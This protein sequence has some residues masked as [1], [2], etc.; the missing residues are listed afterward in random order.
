MALHSTSLLNPPPLPPMLNGVEFYVTECENVMPAETAPFGD[1]AKPFRACTVL[2]SFASGDAER[3]ALLPLRHALAF[4]QTSSEVCDGAE[5]L[6]KLPKRLSERLKSADHDMVLAVVYGGSGGDSDSETIQAAADAL[7]ECFGASL[8]ALLVVSV[9]GS[10]QFRRVRG[11]SGFVVGANGTNAETARAV[12]L[13]LAMFMAPKTLTGIDLFF[14]E[15]VFGTA[16]SPT[17][18]ADAIWLRDGDGSLVFASAADAQAVRCAAQVV[19]FPLIDGPWTWSEL[20][21]FCAAVRAEAIEDTSPIFF[22]ADG[23]ISPSSLPAGIGMVP[24]ICAGA[25]QSS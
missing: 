24:I 9:T 4:G 25:R 16:D 13:C 21:R 12:F 3:A 7:R 22:A 19:A 18:L 5:W 1:P 10:H 2:V 15:P 6:Q 11:I 14:L 8:A 23:A 20:R 17:V